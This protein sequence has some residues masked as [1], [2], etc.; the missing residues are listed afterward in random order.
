MDMSRARNPG[1]G[2]VILEIQKG[3]M[4]FLL[5]CV[6]STFHDI[7]RDTLTSSKVEVQPE[8]AAITAE[9]TGWPTLAVTAAEAPY[10][11]PANINFD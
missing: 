3:I 2:L 10:R 11:V 6:Y 4:D 5:G 8:P 9:A 1:E 7:D